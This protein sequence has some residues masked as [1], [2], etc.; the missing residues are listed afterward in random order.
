MK[1]AEISNAKEPSA[2]MTITL[3]KVRGQ[4]GKAKFIQVEKLST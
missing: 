2:V 3:K 1:K 4:Y